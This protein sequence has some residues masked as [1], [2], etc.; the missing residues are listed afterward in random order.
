M[1]S[2]SPYS[3]PDDAPSVGE[4]EEMAHDDK[5]AR[6]LHPEQFKGAPGHGRSY[7]PLSVEPF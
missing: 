4:A 1:A 7:E 2:S 5:L 6:L 3:N